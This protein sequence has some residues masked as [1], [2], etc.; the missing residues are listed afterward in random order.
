MTQ[1]TF[2]GDFSYS[3]GPGGMSFTL[4][5]NY[6]I[7]ANAQSGTPSISADGRYV[8]FMSDAT[9]LVAGDGNARADV[10]VCDRQTHTIQRV[11]V[12]SSGA[13]A[14]NGS[15]YPA[16]SADGDHVAFVSF[17]SNLV[18]GDTN[19]D[20]DVFVHDRET[21][22][23]ER[24]D[25]AI[26]HSQ[27][28]GIGMPSRPSISTDGRYI[29]FCSSAADLVPNDHNGSPDVFVRDVL[30]DTT[31]RMSTDSGGM[32]ADSDFINSMNACSITADGGLVTFTS[33]ATNLVGGDANGQADVFLHVRQTGATQ[34]VSVTSDGPAGNA[35]GRG[36]AS[37][38]RRRPRRL[39]LVCVEH[40]ARIQMGRTMSSFARFKSG[41]II[42]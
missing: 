22:V 10:L 28:Q 13:E 35:D 12:D 3:L 31:E 18:V 27:A 6:D 7:Q 11:S 24:V 29:A 2:L 38:R 9:N 32:E 19:G 23:T 14:D 4:S 15:F 16:I 42:A 5:A 39:L 20:A 33:H 30:A 1:S 8:A 41:E 21:N 34:R 26:G 40:G 17:A 36:P 25:L 37:Q